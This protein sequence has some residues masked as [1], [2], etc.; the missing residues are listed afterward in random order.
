MPFIRDERDR[1]LLI[2]NN[3]KEQTELMEEIMRNKESKE[4]AIEER[5]HD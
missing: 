3:R 5:D 1:E 2:L 4:M